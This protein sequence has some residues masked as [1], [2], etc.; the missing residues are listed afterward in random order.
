MHD[1][2]HADCLHAVGSCNL[3]GLAGSRRLDEVELEVAMLL[4]DR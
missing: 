1:P 4:I 3:E 2:R